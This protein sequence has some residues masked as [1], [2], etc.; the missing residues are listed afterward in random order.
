MQPAAIV[1]WRDY[2]KICWG[3]EGMRDFFQGTHIWLDNLWLVEE[4]CW[5]QVHCCSTTKRA[6]PGGEALAL[7]LWLQSGQWM[8]GIFLDKL[9]LPIRW[10]CFFVHS[11][12]TWARDPSQSLPMQ[13]LP[14]QG[15]R[16]IFQQA[17]QHADFRKYAEKSGVGLSLVAKMILRPHTLPAA[18]VD[19]FGPKLLWIHQS[20]IQSPERLQEDF[21]IVAQ[22]DNPQWPPYCLRWHYRPLPHQ[23][24]DRLIEAMSQKATVVPVTAS[25][26]PRVSEGVSEEILRHNLGIFLALAKSAGS[27][28]AMLASIILAWLAAFGL[29]TNHVAKCLQP[30]LK[31]KWHSSLGS[32]RKQITPQLQKECTL[33]PLP[34][35]VDVKW[36]ESQ[37]VQ[38]SLFKKLKASAQLTAQWLN[39]ILLHAE[40]NV[41]P[42]EAEDLVEST[43]DREGDVREGCRWSTALS[44]VASAWGRK[45]A[46]RLA[47]EDNRLIQWK[48]GSGA[49][50]VDTGG[51]TSFLS[52]FADFNRILK[53]YLWQWIDRIC[54]SAVSLQ[55]CFRNQVFKN[56]W[57][58]PFGFVGCCLICWSRVETEQRFGIGIL[59]R[60]AQLV[61]KLFH[62]FL[63][64]YGGALR[65]Q[66]GDKAKECCAVLYDAFFLL[67][68]V[69]PENKAMEMLSITRNFKQQNLSGSAQACREILWLLDHYYK[70]RPDLGETTRHLEDLVKLQL[71]KHEIR[72]FFSEA[73]P[74]TDC[75]GQFLGGS[76]IQRS[77]PSYLQADG[78][79][80]L[81][82]HEQSSETRETEEI[83]MQRLGSDQVVFTKVGI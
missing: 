26:Y 61:E 16:P 7:E 34:T 31:A 5:C 28:E 52:L 42:F 50:Q 6:V 71:P 13:M 8:M 41:S 83:P 9:Y 77:P 4:L 51:L 76:G 12:Y 24:R 54:M 60:N 3:L 22:E 36:V 68:G 20:T 23:L 82:L 81:L 49:P 17:L 39:N 79:F 57:M 75:L 2:R 29:D 27:H 62:A 53:S 48:R 73:H 35:Y 66:S 1:V 58:I 30:D 70:D 46:D 19:L 14:E 38:A 33:G 15:S 55:V 78:P 67:F 11:R 63:D 80:G 43:G 56:K 40:L 45:V 47:R 59:L 65:G 37:D 64:G 10:H 44:D 69:T 21:F 74:I 32:F 18:V 25:L 72:R